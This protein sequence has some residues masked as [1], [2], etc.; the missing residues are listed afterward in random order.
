VFNKANQVLGTKD[1]C[2]SFLFSVQRYGLLITLK[3]RIGQ[4]QAGKRERRGEGKGGE[5]RGEEG[6]RGESS[7]FQG[8]LAA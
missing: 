1:I 7:D 2:T 8:L 6:R 3:D 5:G 4:G